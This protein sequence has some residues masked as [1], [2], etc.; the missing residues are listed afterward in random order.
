MTD[1]V[2]NRKTGAIVP[3]TPILEQRT[4]MPDA[5]HLEIIR[6]YLPPGVKRKP[7]RPAKT[8][9]AE[10]SEKVVV[11]TNKASKKK[12]SKKKA[13]KKK[14]KQQSTFAEI[15]EKIKSFTDS[16]DELDE[17]FFEQ[18]GVHLDQ[19]VGVEKMKEDALKVIESARGNASE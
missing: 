6:D 2:K 15:E 8:Q 1:V 3:L 4:T 17:F 12:A 5:A 14:T 9:Q 10:K 19:R 11:T 16:E 18:M 7:G 13:S